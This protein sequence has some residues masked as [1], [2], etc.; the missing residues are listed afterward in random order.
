MAHLLLEAEPPGI[1]PVPPVGLIDHRRH[2]APV[3]VEEPHR[4]MALDIDRGH[5]LARPEIV[6]SV[7]PLR[8]GDAIGDAAAGPAAVEPHD[9]A[10]LLGRAAMH[11]GIDAKPPVMTVEQ[12]L[13]PL[14]KGDVRPPHQRAIGEHPEFA[15]RRRPKSGRSVSCPAAMMPRL[16]SRARV[17]SAS[18]CS[19]SLQRIARCSADRSSEKRPSISSTASLLLRK[20]SRH[21]IGS[22]AAMRVKSRKPPAEYLITSELVTSSRSAAVATML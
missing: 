18:S 5:L 7:R 16:I 4:A 6:E 21:M 2:H 19:P 20:T 22:D 9:Q 11:M 10:R 15:H 13:A 8:L 14:G 3:A 12:C 1:L 17:N